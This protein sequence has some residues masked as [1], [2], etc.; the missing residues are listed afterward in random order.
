MLD[1]LPASSAEFNA[2]VLVSL[3]VFPLVAALVAL[4][5]NRRERVSAVFLIQHAYAGATFPTFVLLL[6]N[7]VHPPA[8]A[9]LAEAD[10]QIY[11]SIAGFTGVV[12]TVTSV[13]RT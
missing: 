13:F 5:G 8:L 6:F 1:W 7:L 3:I 2:W 9:V 10:T 12:L 11:M 4:A